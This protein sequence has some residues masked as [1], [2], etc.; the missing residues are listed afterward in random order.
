MTDRT[1]ARRYAKAL[2]DIG[3]EQGKSEI[4]AENLNAI[5]SLLNDNEELSLM[6][7]NQSIQKDEKKKAKK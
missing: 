7:L 4:F 3:T 1:V 5:A 6:L 2:Y